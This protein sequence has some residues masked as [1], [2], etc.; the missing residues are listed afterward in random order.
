MLIDFG[1]NATKRFEETSEQQNAAAAP[2]AAPQSDSKPDKQNVRDLVLQSL[3]AAAVTWLGT[4]SN[5]EPPRDIEAWVTDKDL[6]DPTNPSLEVRLLLSK[7]QLD[8]LTALLQ[9]VLEAGA[10][11]QVSGDDFFTALQAA[12]TMAA[13]DPEKLA[14]AQD[15]GSPGLI[16]AFL[17]GLPYHSR[18]MDMNNDLW[19]SWGPDE[20]NAFL[21]NLEA[22]LKAYAAIHDDTT[23][24]IAL[25]AGDDPNSYVAPIQLELMP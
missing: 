16:P 22:K 24:W 19:A 10:T 14:N 5:V 4:E 7:A 17:K 1:A 21:N 13:R 18:L 20:Q 11:G 2:D 9:E 12:S 15:L 23:Q 6:T 3:H 8:T 25:N